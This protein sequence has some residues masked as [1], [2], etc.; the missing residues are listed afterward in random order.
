MVDLTGTSV[1]IFGV[2]YAPESTGNA[3]YTTAMAEA[4][5][6]AGADVRIITGIPHYPQWKVNDSTY[7]H[8]LR[9]RERRNDVA[10]DRVRHAVP[11]SPNLF[12]RAKLE[13]TFLVQSL[14]MARGDSSTVILAV[15]PALSGLAAALMCRRG[16]PIG[17]LVQDLTGAAAAQSG[18]SSGWVGWVIAAVE[19]RMLRRAKR[20]GII[21]PQFADVLTRNGIDACKLEHLP[22]FSHITAIDC[23]P[24]NARSRLRWPDRYSV[25]HTGNMGR[26]QGLYTVVDAAKIAEVRG[27]QIQFVLVGD[28]NQ[29]IDLK[30]RAGTCKNISF[31]DALSTTEYPYALAAADVLLVNE[32][33]GVVEMSLP[34]KLTS[35][36]AANRPIVAAVEN[37]SITA[38]KL[39]QHGSALVCRAGSAAALLEAIDTISRSPALEEDLLS[40]AHSMHTLDHDKAIALE[41]YCRFVA[42]VDSQQ[43]SPH[44]QDLL[45]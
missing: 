26:K 38:K 11:A 36:A 28:G 30:R 3:P 6:R 33:C 43:H 9:W 40:A 15:T 14:I 2:H 42:S 21:T 4:L 45:K 23:T 31:V 29:K 20:I 34:S 12:G 25:V 13:F 19:Y 8:G 22:N 32:R 5:S 1:T 39:L 18:T 24:V 41:R 44:R 10:V 37:D 7:Q 27:L 17:V 35:Y 16:R